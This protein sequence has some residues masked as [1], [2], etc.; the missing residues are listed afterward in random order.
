[1]IRW[2]DSLESMAHAI[3]DVP[4][5]GNYFYHNAK[6]VIAATSA[7]VNGY[8]IFPS[9]EGLAKF[10]FAPHSRPEVAGYRASGFPYVFPA[11]CV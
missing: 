4:I 11:E 3:S 8:W 2:N 9:L 5:R 10:G 7:N 6:A 1:L